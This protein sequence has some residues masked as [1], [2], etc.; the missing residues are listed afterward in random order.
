[1]L[2]DRGNTVTLAL[3]FKRVSSTVRF[4]P[5][6]PPVGADASSLIAMRMGGPVNQLKI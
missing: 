5:S 1:M 4:T 3:T 2:G 6:W